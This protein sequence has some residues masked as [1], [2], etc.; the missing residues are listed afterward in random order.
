MSPAL[1][2]G[3]E[4]PVGTAWRR[5]SASW[6]LTLP[7]CSVASTSDIVCG[8]LN[9]GAGGSRVGLEATSVVEPV[10]SLLARVSVL[11]SRA[12]APVG[13]LRLP[14]RPRGGE[15]GGSQ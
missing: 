11:A 6:R 15:A 10:V 13:S 1:E 9:G 4:P 2:T 7:I 8:E 5:S 14:P 12:V 3:G